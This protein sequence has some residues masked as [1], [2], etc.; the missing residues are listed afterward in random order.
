MNLEEPLLFMQSLAAPQ[1]PL[2]LGELRL[3]HPCILG[4]CALQTSCIPVKCRPAD[5]LVKSRAPQAVCQNENL[6][7][8]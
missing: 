2:H 6:T 1:T 8:W 3:Q 5:P 4:S 7:Q